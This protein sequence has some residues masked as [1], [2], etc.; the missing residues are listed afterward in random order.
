M[1]YNFK[2]GLP[3]S[4]LSHKDHEIA[5]VKWVKLN[6]ITE[7]GMVFGHDRRIVQAEEYF[8]KYLLPWWK[9]FIKRLF[10]C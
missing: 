2:D 1:I 3:L 5:D 6:N 7:Y 9:R 4:V 10:H 8:C